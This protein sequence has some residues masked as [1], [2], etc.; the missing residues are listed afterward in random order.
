MSTYTLYFHP[1]GGIVGAKEHGGCGSTSVGYTPDGFGLPV[2]AKE[3][4]DDLAFVL[5]QTARLLDQ[6]ENPEVLPGAINGQLSAA[7]A[8]LTRY[9]EATER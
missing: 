3:A 1:S 8:A 9:R 6:Y 7:E 5:E 2:V 4:A